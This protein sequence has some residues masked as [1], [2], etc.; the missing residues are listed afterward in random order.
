MSACGFQPKRLVH[1]LLEEN[2]L[3]IQIY[4]I[5][6]PMWYSVHRLF[7]RCSGRIAAEPRWWPASAPGANRWSTAAQERCLLPG[8]SARSCQQKALQSQAQAGN[9]GPN[10][11]W[12]NPHS[13]SSWLRTNR[14]AYTA[15]HIDNKR[16]TSTQRGE[17]GELVGKWSKSSENQSMM[18]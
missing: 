15:L 6:V 3:L 13:L 14:S 7:T 1:S 9:N 2:I 10:A 4:M 17:E 18:V 11:G 12:V 5:S 8:G 16:G